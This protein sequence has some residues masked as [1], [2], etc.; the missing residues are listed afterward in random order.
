MAA[1]LRPKGV[2]VASVMPGRGRVAALLARCWAGL[3]FSQTAMQDGCR[4]GLGGAEGRDESMADLQQRRG[5]RVGVV[6]QN[7]A[8]LGDDPVH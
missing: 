5:R 3:F 8:T 6:A 2:G 7:A 1:P 4:I